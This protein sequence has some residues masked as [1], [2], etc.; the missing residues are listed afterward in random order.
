MTLAKEKIHVYFVQYVLFICFINLI[1]LLERK[2]REVHQT[3]ICDI[4][5]SH[6]Q[7]LRKKLDCLCAKSRATI[8]EKVYLKISWFSNES[9]SHV[10]FVV[11]VLA[12]A[13]MLNNMGLEML[14]NMFGGLGAG[15]GMTVP[16][17]SDGCCSLS[18]SLSH[19]WFVY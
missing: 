18:L 3:H 7:G 10:V 5:Y 8:A 15:G 16:S 9:I 19:M 17:R 1:Q 2:A 4:Q 14:M 6:T 13:G 12:I 11:N